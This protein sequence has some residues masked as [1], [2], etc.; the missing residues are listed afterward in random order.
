MGNERR[1]RWRVA[2]AVVG[3]VGWTFY[4]YRDAFAV[5]FLNEDFTWLLSCRFRPDRG[6][7]TL[8]SQDVMGGKYSWRPLL[9]LSFGVNYAVWGLNPWG[10]RLGAVAWQA[11]A[12]GVVYAIAAPRSNRFC[13]LVAAVVFAAHHVEVETLTWTCAR[14]S[15]ISTTFI[16]LG[17]WGYWRWRDHRG[18]VAFVLLPF[19]LALAT[20]ENVAVFPALLL[21]V[22]LLWAAPAARARR[23]GLY[24]S[25]LAIIAGA[26]LLRHA[27][28]PTATDFTMVGLDPRWPVTPAG[29][30]DF[31]LAK[32]Q[33]AAAMLLGLSPGGKWAALPL[34]AVLLAAA[35]AAWW[36][37]APL[38]L[39]GF[40]WVV[41]A[42]AP[43][44]LLL[45]GPY[46]RH[47]S[48]PLAGFA[49]LCGALTG[50]VYDAA[51]RWNRYAAA[52]CVGLL[53]MLWLGH[54]VRMIDV[55]EATYLERGRL[56]RTLLLDM[57]RTL[58]HPHPGSTLAFHGVGD[59]RRRGSVLVFGLEDAV[60][61]LYTD[62]SLRVE[63]RARGRVTDDAYHL[64][65]HDG[66]LDLLSSDRQ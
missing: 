57:L 55:Q 44:S 40:L 12:A 15:V 56:T 41:C 52:G 10:Y 27:I 46:P 50:A 9:Q 26:L 5:Y 13:A 38:A 51:A 65:Y 30:V 2:L 62:D 54:M 59:L 4:V 31:L 24:L 66:R 60:R 33:A 39:W 35:L 45:L 48:L 61:L 7:W 64:V 43:F 17:V 47:L 25:L 53:L 34:T 14:S 20:Q 29:L 18:S 1:A 6:P 16:L 32:A 19:L 11:L 37:G 28:S 49:L 63:F 22:D 23:L 42:F 58:P 3:L 36:R 8:L 21:V